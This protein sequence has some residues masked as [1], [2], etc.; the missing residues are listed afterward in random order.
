MS[1]VVIIMQ[2]AEGL[3]AARWTAAARGC[4]AGLWQCWQSSPAARLPTS[5]L[6]IASLG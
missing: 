3:Y 4:G 6:F 5:F 2:K 1:V